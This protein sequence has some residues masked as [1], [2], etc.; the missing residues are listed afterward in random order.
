ME[1]RM[2]SGGGASALV[3]AVMLAAAL[4]AVSCAEKSDS[5]RASDM[6]GLPVPLDPQSV[7]VEMDL[8]EAAKA[9]AVWADTS[10]P[11]TPTTSS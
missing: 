9:P 3:A 7:T 1:D 5:G 11:S 2:H 10:R 6:N 4:V 8:L